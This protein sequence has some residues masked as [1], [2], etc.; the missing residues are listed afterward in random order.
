MIPLCARSPAVKNSDSL[1]F[2]LVIA[3]TEASSECSGTRAVPLVDLPISVGAGTGKFPRSLRAR[4]R[5]LSILLISQDPGHVDKGEQHGC[6]DRGDHDRA[7]ERQL[8]A[9]APQLLRRP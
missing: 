1:A 3:W 7:E 8:S 4:L 2:M 6:C 5:A 9:E